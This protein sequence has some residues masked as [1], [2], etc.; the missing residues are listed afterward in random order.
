MTGRHKQIK[1]DKYSQQKKYENRNL[2]GEMLIG[3]GDL[4]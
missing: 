3:R 2:V 1:G 4:G